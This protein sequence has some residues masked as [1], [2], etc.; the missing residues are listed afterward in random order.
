MVASRPRPPADHGRRQ[1]R[2]DRRP[3]RAPPH[4][5]R[6]DAGRARRDPTVVPLG[7]SQVIIVAVISSSARRLATGLI[8]A[9]S[10]AYTMIALLYFQHGAGYGVLATIA[11]TAVVTTYSLNMRAALRDGRPPLFPLTLV[12]QAIATYLPELLPGGWSAVAAPMLAGT[13]LV[14]LPLRWGG[15]L[16]GLMMV[17]EGAVL[18][19]S[20]AL[21]VIVAF[22]VVTVPT[23]GAMTYAL[24]RFVRVTAEL[25][26]ARAELADAA[27]LKERLRIS[28]D[29]HDGLGRSLTAIALKGD[30]A[31]RL[32]DGDPGS[33]R[34]EVGQ[35]V[36]VAR[37]AA[38]DVRQVAKGYR[39]VSL[40]GEVDKAVALLQ[41]SGVGAQAHLADVPLPRRSEEAL[42]WAVREGVTNVLRHSRATTCTITTSLQ[43]GAIRLEVAND[44]AP[45]GSG[46][47]GGGLTGLAER[48]AQA[49]GSCAA[50]PTGTGGF[51]LAVEVAA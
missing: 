43:N 31:A 25:E 11:I 2:Q 26:E 19:F 38:K 35:L 21:P 42:A 34:A 50:T 12:L 41:S 33:A 15:A 47:R 14:F 8:V 17:Y 32:M 46:P 23:T 24:V 13:L 3:R 48:A 10:C 22:Y 9:V 30:L 6:V 37:E 28:R 5:G 40:A 27:V 51:L 7:A 36:Q 16:V 20:G 39:A 44:G 29:L 45:T 4:S 49:G 1:R 18:T